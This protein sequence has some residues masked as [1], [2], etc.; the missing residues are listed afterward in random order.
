MHVKEPG[1]VR[2]DNELKLNL[3]WCPPGKFKMGSPDSEKKHHDGEDQVDVVL[4]TGF[5]L[6]KYEVTQS[7]WK[8]VMNTEPW[9]GQ[10]VQGDD[11]PATFVDWDDAAEFCR[12]LTE[13]DRKAGHLPDKWEYV[14]PTEAQ[15]ESACRAGTETSFSFGDNEPQL[16]QYAWYLNNADRARQSHAHRVG[17]LKPN[18]WGLYDM[19]GNVW[20]W[21][22]DIYGKKLPGGRNPEVQPTTKTW[23]VDRVFRGGGW[24]SDAGGCRS[25]FRIR[26]L[27]T[28]GRNSFIGLR[29]ACCTVE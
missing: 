14:L 22:R 5:W 10:D 19:H 16:C 26:H 7:E 15:W 20:E 17:L 28:S 13:L 3:V 25:A 9:R 23:L 6:G 29:V 2:D 11:Y 21:C 18:P 27:P 24:N 8:R 1:E 4:T 12:K